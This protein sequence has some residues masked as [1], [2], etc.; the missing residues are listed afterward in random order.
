[1]LSNIK[2]FSSAEFNILPRVSVP[3][4]IIAFSP[5][6]ADPNK[7]LGKFISFPRDQELVNMLY[8]NKMCEVTSFPKT[9]SSVPTANDSL[10]E[11]MKHSLGGIR[12]RGITN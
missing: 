4:A 3:P 8:L 11:H 7:H 1:M 2:N 9:R 10:S 6:L 12:G 5:R